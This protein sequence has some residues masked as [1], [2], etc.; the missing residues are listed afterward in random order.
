MLVLSRQVDD[1]VI[2]HAKISKLKQMIAEAE[3]A[4]LDKVALVAVTV[5]KIG[6]GLARIGFEADTRIDIVRYE[7]SEEAETDVRS[8]NSDDPGHVP[9]G[10]KLLS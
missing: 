3:A 1:K 4:G 2:T 8:N 9:V 7:I 6:G 10:N 5:V